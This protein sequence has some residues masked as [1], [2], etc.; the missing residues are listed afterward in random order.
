MAILEVS[1]GVNVKY[2]SENKSAPIVVEYSEAQESLQR[3]G[4]C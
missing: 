3:E 1:H 4:K 2:I